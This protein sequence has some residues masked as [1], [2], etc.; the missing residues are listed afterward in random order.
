LAIK[1]L[2]SKIGADLSRFLSAEHLASW[3]GMCPGNAESGGRRLIPGNAGLLQNR[4]MPRRIRLYPYLTEHE[5]HERYRQTHD[6]VERSRWQFLWL[7]ARVLT[8]R[9][10]TS[11]STPVRRANCTAPAGQML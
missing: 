6:P 5:L 7:L 4:G 9:Q 1:V 8:A 3:V 10:T 2:I 11:G